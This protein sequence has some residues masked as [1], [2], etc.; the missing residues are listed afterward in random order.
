MATMTLSWQT[1]IAIFLATL[2]QDDVDIRGD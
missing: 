1:G 2:I